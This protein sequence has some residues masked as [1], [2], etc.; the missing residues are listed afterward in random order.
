M[1]N[2]AAQS[3]GFLQEYGQIGVFVLFGAFFAFFNLALSW[4]VRVRNN[5]SLFR[6]TYEC[7]P[8]TVGSPWVQINVRFYLFAMLFVLFD[9][10]TIFIYPWAVA[11]RGLGLM[12]FLEMIVFIGVLFLGLIYA[13]KKGGLEWK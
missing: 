11:Y 9:V 12:G 2:S 5:D 1:M 7:G 3:M 8:D 4:L 13:W 10:E 6:T